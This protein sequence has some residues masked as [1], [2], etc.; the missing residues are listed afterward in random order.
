MIYRVLGKT[1]LKVS[2]LGFGCG[3]VGGLLVRG[4]PQTIRQVLARAIDL[5]INYFD[6]AVMYG[7]GKSEANLGSA[8]K[9]LGADVVV[10]TKVRLT[11]AEMENIPEAVTASVE[12]S[13]KR[14]KRDRVDLIQLHNPI[15]RQRRS[16]RDWVE[17]SDVEPVVEA[18]RSLQEQG[19][20]RFW[21]ITGLGETE[22]LLRVIDS[23]GADTVQALYNLINPTAAREANQ[24]FPFQDFQQLIDRAA[25]CQMGVLAIRI[26][27][28]GAL[29]GKME[30]Q[31]LAAP[32]VSPIAS[33]TDY[34]A[35]IDRS[36]AF[37]IL[38][39]QGIA[40]DLVEV[41]I[42][43]AVSKAEVSTALLGISELD[44]L[45]RAV[46]YVNR[47]PLPGAAHDLLSEIWNR[48]QVNKCF[49]NG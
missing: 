20:V 26:L 4:D 24:G 25:A 31:S 6:T 12:G 5:G 17:V 15:G 47:G 33:D 44:Q 19:K 23:A 8:L 1:G 41:A 42:R 40:G 28:G 16:D 10:G 27:A 13:L 36:N 32:S 49:S 46:K 22:A 14:L 11:L 7:E 39:E 34:S 9:E 45:E 29:S 38:V 18:F 2:A 3:N 37:R 30:R 35:D 48:Y 43:F 21:G